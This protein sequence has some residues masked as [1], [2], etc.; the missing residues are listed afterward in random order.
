MRK[1]SLSWPD[2]LRVIA[3]I[4]M[5]LLHV[6]S[7]ILLRYGEISMITWHLGNLIDSSVRFCVPVFVM[8]SGALLLQKE[9]SLKDF[10]QKRFMRVL[11]P[12]AFYSVVYILHDLDAR[13]LWAR[14]DLFAYIWSK[15]SK[16]A[17]YHLWYIYMIIGLY[18]FIPV[19]GRWVRASS[20]KD[21]MYFL[22]IWL[23]TIDISHPLILK[24]VPNINL[25]YFSGF[26]GYL[27]LGYYLALKKNSGGWKRSLSIYLL[28]AG[29]FVTILSTFL[30]SA[31]K[32]AYVGIYYGYLTPNVLL[33]SVGLFMLVNNFR[34]SG[35]VPEKIR[36]FLCRYSYGIY[37]VHVLVYRV[38]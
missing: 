5:V 7:P 4:S 3:T 11:V 13:N 29:V 22:I 19:I 25:S 26:L 9:Y 27:V 15:V 36:S 12:F 17:A 35:R 6:T 38:E 18:L 1:E 10:F 24:L 28:L 20:E 16:G 32:G 23:V 30:H 34:F 8:L 14:E 33:T 31:D 21:I 2:N 37:L